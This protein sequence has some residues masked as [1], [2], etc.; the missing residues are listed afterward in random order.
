LVVRRGDVEVVDLQSHNGTLVNGEPIAG[1]RALVS[2]DVMA[3]GET[4]L[5]FHS[6]RQQRGQH[7]IEFA[8]LRRRLREELERATHFGRPLSVLVLELNA[9]DR[10]LLTSTVAA[11]TRPVDF[12][13]WAGESQLIAVFPELDAAA[14]PDV[15]ALLL[16]HGVKAR[17]GVASYPENGVD[18]DAL[19]AAARSGAGGAAPG[20]LGHVI[21]APVRVELGDR[22]ILLADSVMVRLF[23]LVRRLARGDLPVLITGET[24]VGKESAAQ[25]VHHWSRRKEARF[26]PINC[27]ALPETLVESEL[28]GY[29]KGAFSGAAAAKPGLLELAA[30]GTVFFDEVGELPAATQAKLLRVLEEKKLMRLGATRELEVDVRIVAATN[31]DLEAEVEAGKFRRD[32]YYRLSGATVILPPLRDR[33]RELALL[34][35]TFLAEACARL[36]RE[37]PTL[38]PSAIAALASHSWPGNVRELKNAMEYI[39][40]AAEEVVEPAHLPE[41]VT[42]AAKSAPPSPA[43]SDD[44]DEAVTGVFRPL[45]DEISE[46]EKSRLKE[47]MVA[48]G[49]VKAKAARLIGMPLRTF[50]A[51]LKQYSID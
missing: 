4:S 34:M 48:S 39:A 7:P 40:A 10:Q 25:A 41:R 14:L 27:A 8:T 11:C 36:G 26:V 49:G 9:V 35:R 16:P 51:K 6:A 19:I 30:G 50:V 15:S 33:P 12:M 43:A 32:L 42:R 44:G 3:I 21:D 5:V 1:A 47:A 20:K 23:E 2:G 13:T 24:G 18:G 22:A 38:A 17:A 29:E 31:R 46:L 45:S 37:T 28:F